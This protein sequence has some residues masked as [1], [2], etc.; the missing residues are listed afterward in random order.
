MDIG[1]LDPRI[2]PY[3]GDIAAAHLKGRVSAQSFVEGRLMQ[4]AAPFTDMM[5]EAQGGSRVSQALHGERFTLYQRRGARGWGQLASDGY[6][7]WVALADLREE[8]GLVPTHRVSALLTRATDI[9]IKAIGFGP[10]PMG[11]L[12]AI[13]EPSIAMRGSSARFAQSSLGAV[14]AAHLVELNHVHPDWV[15]VAQ[16]F[17]G[18]PYVWG[19][20]TAMGLDCSA[21]VQLALQQAGVPCPRDSDLQEAGPGH[22]LASGAALLRGD[23]V[24]WPG[25]VGIMLDSTKLLHANA[26]AMAVSIEPLGNVEARTGAVRSI[27]R[28]P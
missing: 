10:L 24:F 19:G 18:V 27:R 3:K 26:Y 21:L 14:P 16:M 5:D 8:D 12:L 7:G 6:I 23:L 15:S 20:R 28:L 2:H 25:H 4:I 11:C 22:A 13:T 9:S 1:S 17:L